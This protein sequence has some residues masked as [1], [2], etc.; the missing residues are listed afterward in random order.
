MLRA[1]KLLHPQHIYALKFKF[2]EHSLNIVFHNLF[3]FEA[4]LISNEDLIASQ[5]YLKG[6]K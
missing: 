1:F 5:A 4:P 2:F 3:Y 6:I